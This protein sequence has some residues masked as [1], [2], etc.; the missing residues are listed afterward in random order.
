MQKKKKVD[1]K[2]EIKTEVTDSAEEVKG[3]I[4]I[5]D[6]K[7]IQ[8]PINLDFLSPIQ[9]IQ[10]ASFAQ[11][12][13]NKNLLKF[14]AEDNML[15][16]LATSV[17]ENLKPLFQEDTSYTPSGRLKSLINSVDKHF[18]SFETL[19]AEKALNDFNAKRI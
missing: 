7:F 11:A 15:L 9:K 3:K 14:H 8:G 6:P 13:A 17:L 19:A 10:L 2:V 12:K 18:K 4:V 1:V 16:N 5:D